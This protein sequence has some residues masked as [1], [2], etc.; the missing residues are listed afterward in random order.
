MTSAHEH[1][2]EKRGERSQQRDAVGV[3]AKNFLC[4]L[5]HPIHAARGLQHTGTGHCGYDDIDHISRWR[6][7]FEMKAEYQNGQA[8][9]GNGSKGKTSVAG[10]YPQ[11]PEHHKELYDHEY[12]HNSEGLMIG[13]FRA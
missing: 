3:L 10:T 12:R 5:Y 13:T 7:R 4:Y 9:A 11:C 1:G 2:E 8:Y 6:T